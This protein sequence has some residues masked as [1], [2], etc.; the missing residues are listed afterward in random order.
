MSEMKAQI[1][2]TMTF[3]GS[4]YEIIGLSQ[5]ILFCPEDFGF[6]PAMIHTGCYDGFYGHYRIAR[7]NLFLDRLTIFSEDRAYPVLNG[8]YPRQSRE[9]YGCMVYDGIRLLI[10]FTGSVRLGRGFICRYYV[11]LGYQKPSGYRTV[12]DCSFKHGVL[13]HFI[14]RSRE[15]AAIRGKFKEE[16]CDQANG[17]VVE[18]IDRAFSLGMEF[19]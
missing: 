17:S 4:I 8:S 10:P 11:R 1:P 5:N 18:K 3:R 6:R 16:F 7:K 13:V 9:E 14:N 15:A 12:I 19:L 2:N